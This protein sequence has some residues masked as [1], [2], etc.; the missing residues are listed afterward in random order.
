M[1]DNKDLI[2]AILAVLVPAVVAFMGGFTLKV[3]PRVKP[4]L[5]G[6]RILN[7]QWILNNTCQ[8]LRYYSSSMAQRC[9]DAHK[10]LPNI[11]A[12]YISASNLT[13]LLNTAF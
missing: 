11:S 10:R 13:L 3:K 6:P 1:N 12:P 7:S 4:K 8:D 2:I 5:L 9:P